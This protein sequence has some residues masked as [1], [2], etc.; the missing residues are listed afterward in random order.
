[1]N[2]K[3]TARSLAAI[4][5]C[6]LLISCRVGPQ[7]VRADVP[8]DRDIVD[9]IAAG[10]TE[11]AFDLLAST[12]P[13]AEDLLF[14]RGRVLKAEGQ[15]DAAIAVFREV[16]E[17]EP[18]YINA[19]REL[20]HTLLLNRS[21]EASEFHFRELLRSDTDMEQRDG[22]WRFLDLI[23]RERPFG[24][25][26]QFA[27]LP[28]TNVN[29]GSSRSIFDPGNPDIPPLRIT[30]RSEAGVGVLLGLSGFYR[31]PFADRFRWSLDWGLH[32]RKYQNTDYDSVTASLRTG[33]ERRLDRSRWSFGAFTRA[34]LRSDDEDIRV[35]GLDGS[36]ERSV[37]PRSS[38]FL[39]AIYEDRR[40]PNL[41]GSDG[42]FYSAQ[43]GLSRLI[44]PDTRLVFGSRLDANR[45]DTRHLGY[46]GY[47]VFGHVFR[48]WRRGLA[49][50]TGLEFGAR[51]YRGDFPLT[52]NRRADDFIRIDT[53]VHTPRW[54]I[55]GFTPTTTCSYTRNFSNVAFFDYDVAECHLSFVRR[56]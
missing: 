13:T 5:L 19:R 21:F 25:S 16:I 55:R 29:R 44:R 23:D 53:T 7:A 31:Q 9:L 51:R 34:S 30:N 27:L 28:S 14:F 38:L 40:Y 20:A 41:D 22:Y 26:A 33:V 46:D 6:A 52:D 12:N 36:I 11:A 48:D 43:L 47:A 17:R 18:R 4:I 1:M 39:N 37:G 24:V 42:P 35:L 3:G 15:L 2:R 54:S 56:Y 32:G 49:T 8:Q 45:P 10:Q 50:E